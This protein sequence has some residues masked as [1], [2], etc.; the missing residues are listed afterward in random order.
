[1]RKNRAYFI[2][3]IKL[4]QIILGVAFLFLGA[5]GAYAEKPSYGDYFV[6]GSIGD[7]RNLVP[8]L[9]SDSSSSDIVGMVFNGLVKYDKDL[10]LIGDLAKSWEI[11]DGGLTIIFHLRDDVKWHDGVRFGA[12]DVEFTYKKLIDPK[13]TTPYSGDFERVKNFE[14]IDDYTVKITYKEPFSPGLSSWGMPIMPEH[15]LKKEDLNKTDFSRHP[16]GTGPYKFKNWKTAEKIVLDFNPDYFEGRPYIDKYIY[17]I[18]PDEATMFLELRTQS[19]DNMGLSPLQFKKETDSDFFKTHF[20]KFKYPSSSY[21]YMGFNLNDNKFKDKAVRQAINYAIDKKEIIDIVLLGLGRIATGPFLPESWAYNK[22]VVPYEYNPGKAK[23]L[24]AEAGWADS[25]NDGIL[26]KN[27]QKFEFTIVTNQGNEQ[28]KQAAEIIQARL[29]KVG[30]KVNIKILEWSVFISQFIDKRRFEA[31][32]L[33]WS[34]PRDPDC[35]DI[36]YSSKIKE[37]EFNFVGYDNP[38]VDR[39]LVEARREFDEKI[40]AEYYKKI[41]AILYDDSP[42]IFLFVPYSLPIVN[43]RFHGIKAAPAGIGYNFIKWF[44]PEAEQRYTR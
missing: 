25:N 12:K 4:L 26:E 27:G 7:A 10:I 8:I 18:I 31:V 30:I 14:V 38:E 36:F 29:S 5:L 13:I 15:I 37:G 3:N 21:V 11:L 35:Y 1:M 24:L 20:Q 6:T 32:L 2:Y 9:A 28:R 34:L 43:S 19:I 39:L 22:D 44:V 23:E 42:Y 41:Q 40:R 33:G 17:K 16:I